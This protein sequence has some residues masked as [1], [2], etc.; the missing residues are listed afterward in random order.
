MGDPGTA[1]ATH[2]SAETK[3]AKVMTR[4]WKTLIAIAVWATSHAMLAQAPIT[5]LDIQAENRVSY[6]HDIWDYSKIASD[7]GIAKPLR[8]IK[9]FQSATYINYIVAVNGK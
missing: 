8:S 2:D 5:I 1:I 7:P 3:G 9:P 6:F 4:N